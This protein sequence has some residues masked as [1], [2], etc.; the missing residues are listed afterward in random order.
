MYSP[1]KNIEVSIINEIKNLYEEQSY[2]DI[3][4]QLNEA[5][6]IFDNIDQIKYNHRT[7]FELIYFI[8]INSSEIFG[9]FI[10]S[11]EID[12]NKANQFLNNFFDNY[13]FFEVERINNKIEIHFSFSVNQKEIKQFI[14]ENFQKDLIT[15]IIVF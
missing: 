4:S 1:L 11:D 5:L 13:L 8:I 2:F 7:I 6:L 10:E 9:R 14:P 3:L 15:E 12:F